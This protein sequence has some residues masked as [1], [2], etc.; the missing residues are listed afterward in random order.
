MS[1]K[2]SGLDDYFRQKVQ[3][4]LDACKA[5]GI[6]V[7][8]TS[9]LRTFDEQDKLYAQGRTSPGNVVTKAKAGQSAHN[10]GK[11]VDFCVL[12]DGKCAWNAP[13]SEW[14]AVGKIAEGLGLI[15]GGSW[16]NFQDLPHIEDGSWRDDRKARGL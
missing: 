16:I 2:L 1:D 6:E 11:A 3:V 4:I 9:G 12:H 14:E 10:Y 13:R 7:I 8:I 15:W 5:N